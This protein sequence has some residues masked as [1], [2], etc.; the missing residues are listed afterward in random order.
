MT[1][2]WFFI[3]TNL[4]PFIQGC[5]VPSLVEIGSVVLEKI[6]M[7][8]VTANNDNHNLDG[9]R[10]NLI[11]KAHLSLRLREAKIYRLKTWIPS[12]QKTLCVNWLILAGCFRKQIFKTCQ[13]YYKQIKINT[14]K[15]S[16][17]TNLIFFVIQAQGFWRKW[18]FGKGYDPS[19]VWI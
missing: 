9:Q 19:F 12:T 10:T 3:W 15:F 5:F 8:K 2:H 7:W 18:P 1:I 6:K 14:P 4:N 16:I 13:G 11:K 17:W